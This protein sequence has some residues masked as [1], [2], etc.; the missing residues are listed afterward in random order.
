MMSLP[1]AP[2]PYCARPLAMWPH[3]AVVYHCHECQRPLGRYPMRRNP[4]IY[5]IF[6]VIAA[7]KVVTA[8]GGALILFALIALRFPLPQL[9]AAV[10]EQLALYGAAD[11]TDGVLGLSSRIDRTGKRVRIGSG[12]KSLAWGKIA[13]GLI[14]CLAA[15]VGFLVVKGAS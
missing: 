2:C 14:N 8:I 1:A 5:R 3:R 4:G 13:F 10:A 11:I 9:A 7:I 12:A 15:A 6:S